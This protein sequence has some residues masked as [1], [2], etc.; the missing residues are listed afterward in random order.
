MTRWELKIRNERESWDYRDDTDTQ[1]KG[2]VERRKDNEWIA[3]VRNDLRVFRGETA[4]VDAMRYVERVT[5]NGE[6][7]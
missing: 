5:A 3:C 2:V 6:S 4:L 1:V 7:R